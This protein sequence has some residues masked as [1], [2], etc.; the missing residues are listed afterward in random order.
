MSA[1]GAG[2][3]ATTV[4]YANVTVENQLR[5]AGAMVATGGSSPSV[6]ISVA[7]TLPNDAATKQYVDD[8]I[9]AAVPPSTASPTPATLCLRDG[10]GS[11]GL[12]T[13]ILGNGANRSTL[14]PGV[15][16]ANKTFS[17]PVITA[18]SDVVVGEAAVETLTN[19]TIVGATNTVSANALKT[20]G[21]DVTVSAAA[22]PTIGASLVATSPTNAAWSMTGWTA[23][24]ATPAGVV[25][26]AT[27]SPSSYAYF[28]RT[29][30]IAGGVQTGEVIEGKFRLPVNTSGTGTLSFSVNLPV[31]GTYAN[32]GVGTGLGNLTVSATAPNTNN[33][34]SVILG[35]ST[36]ALTVEITN[37]IGAT[38]MYVDFTCV[39]TG[40]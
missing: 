35:A 29:A 3:T 33:G 25:G 32:V 15:Q 26:P 2:R 12:T 9:T 16:A 30:L 40:P 18:A 8:A 31:A 13:V 38:G 19:K 17:L 36:L 14:G 21:A 10:T 7:P 23:Y 11:T 34:V 6:S 39:R 5:V 22:P 37:N 24:T 1:I 27:V 4:Q 20:T 28:T